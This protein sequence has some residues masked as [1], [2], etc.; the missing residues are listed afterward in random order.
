MILYDCVIFTL[1]SLHVT[2]DFIFQFAKVIFECL[3]ERSDLFLEAITSQVIMPEPIFNMTQPKRRV[4]PFEYHTPIPWAPSSTWIIS[5]FHHFRARAEIQRGN[6][7]SQVVKV[8]ICISLVQ[9]FKDWRLHIVCHLCHYLRLGLI[10]DREDR[11]ALQLLRW[12]LRL[13]KVALGCRVVE[14]A[15]ETL[16]GWVSTLILDL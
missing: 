3:I 13:L 11:G 12:R 4:G 5:I 9:S 16:L 1:V 8:T 14:G 7:G 10:G 2:H 6:W 15:V